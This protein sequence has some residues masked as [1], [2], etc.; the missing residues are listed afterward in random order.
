MSGLLRR[1]RGERAAAPDPAP[2]QAAAW[3]GEAPTREQPAGED[4][5][6]DTAVLQEDPSSAPVLP[7]GVDLDVL[8]GE[9]PTTQRRGRLRRR[10]RHLRRVREVLLRDLGG[11]VFELRRSADLVT[12]DTGDRLV[13]EKLRRLAAVNQ[14]LHEL[15]AVLDDR[16][17]MVLREPGIGGTCSVC[18]E[19]FGSDARFCWACGTPV[20]PGAA[21][22]VTPVAPPPD[23]PQIA[24]PPATSWA[25]TEPA[26]ESDSGVAEPVIEAEA[27]EEHPEAI[28][29]HPDP[30]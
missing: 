15:E 11:L 6:G 16:R 3:P 29:E 14:E 27:I 5:A 4:T 17:G 8:V 26:A 28:E 1:I 19:L 24:T 25:Q 12:G 2:D 21:H 20:A 22:P 7:A 9:R 10:L 18:G 13:D 30:R 23:V